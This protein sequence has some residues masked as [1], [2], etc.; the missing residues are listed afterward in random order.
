MNFESKRPF[1]D[2]KTFPRGIQRSGEFTINEAKI[3][4]NHGVAM[5][6]LY[7]GQQPPEDEHE[8]LFLERVQAGDAQDNLHARVWLKYLKISGPKKVH[9]L[10]DNAQGNHSS[11]YYPNTSK[12]DTA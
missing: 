6:S 5:K 7:L 2:H 12:S 4:E 3:L 1:I 8:T 10:C 11:D 9:R